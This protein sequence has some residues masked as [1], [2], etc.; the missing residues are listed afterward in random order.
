VKGISQLVQSSN[1]G[2]LVSITTSLVPRPCGRRENE[3]NLPQC[4][5]FKRNWLGGYCHCRWVL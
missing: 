4:M 3:I 1:A 5:P 2:C